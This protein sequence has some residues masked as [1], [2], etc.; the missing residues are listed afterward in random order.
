MKTEKRKCLY[1]QLQDLGDTLKSYASQAAMSHSFKLPNNGGSS[2][3]KDTLKKTAVTL[4]A[5]INFIEAYTQ[6][7]KEVEDVK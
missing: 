5:Y 6:E 3:N 2:V 1:D 7:V 4:Q